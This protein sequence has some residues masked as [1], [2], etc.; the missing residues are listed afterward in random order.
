MY[1]DLGL[2]VSIKRIVGRCNVMSNAQV[3][4]VIKKSKV[5]TRQSV[6]LGPAGFRPTR[7]LVE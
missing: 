4:V 5:E 6:D 1:A 3:S 2:K 7:R